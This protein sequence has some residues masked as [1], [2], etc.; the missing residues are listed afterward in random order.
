MGGHPQCDFGGPHASNSPPQGVEF[1]LLVTA[2]N[3]VPH[4]Y[5][6]KSTQTEKQ[7]LDCSLLKGRALLSLSLTVDHRVCPKWV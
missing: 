5:S 1:K 7:H 3:Q 2:L 6:V 4:D